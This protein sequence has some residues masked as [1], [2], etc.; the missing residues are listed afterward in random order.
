MDTTDVWRL[1]AQA[2]TDLPDPCEA[3]DIAARAI[4]LLA[5]RPPAYIA[6]FAQ[7]LWDLL[8]RS[9]RADL[10]AAAYTING[11]AS[12]DGFDYFRGWLIAQGEAVYDQAL[13]DPDSLADQP[14]VIRA[15]A[16][17]MELSGEDILG[18][19]WTA[20]RNATGEELPANAFTIT[21]PDL[22]PAWDFDFDD[23]EEIRRRLPKLAALFLEPDET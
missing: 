20:Y 16:D 10:W 18:I 4:S 17:E 13:T 8:A 19:A 23:P 21:Y 7:P 14:A 11:G 6:A 2:R 3:E 22:D 15:A 5:G 1:L 12:D 9:Y